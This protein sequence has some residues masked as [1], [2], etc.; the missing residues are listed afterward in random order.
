MPFTDLL[1][2]TVVTHNKKYNIF[3]PVEK[4]YDVK[5]PL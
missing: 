1:M 2:L 5:S 3:S 4:E